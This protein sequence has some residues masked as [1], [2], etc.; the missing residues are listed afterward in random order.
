M[1]AD[2][3]GFV[4]FEAPETRRMGGMRISIVPVRSV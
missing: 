3:A 1:P 4:V 2:L